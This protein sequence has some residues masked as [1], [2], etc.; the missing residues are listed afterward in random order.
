MT[1][2]FYLHGWA[3]SPQSSKAQFFKQCFEQRGLSLQIPDL[4][5]NDFYHFSLTQQI[6]QVE[7]LLPNSPVTIIGS[8]FG[9]L[10]ALWLAERLPQIQSIVLLAPALNF[11]NHCRILMG[12]S[13]FAQWR[14]QGEFAFTNYAEPGERLISYGFIEDLQQYVDADLQRRVPSLILHGNQDM[15]VPIQT[16]RDFAATRPWIKLVEFDSDHR[17]INVQAQLWQAIQASESK[18]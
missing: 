10:I 16:S 1:T 17:L 3:S 8:S 7:A 15:V 11:L 12:E 13:N 6:Q 5:P 4:N 2:F 18:L 14:R 9:G